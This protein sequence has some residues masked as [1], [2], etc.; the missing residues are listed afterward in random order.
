[1]QQELIMLM[2]IS[3]YA[4]GK[5]YAMLKKRNMDNYQVYLCGEGL[6]IQVLQTRLLVMFTP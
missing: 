5:T 2:W 1:M 3:K 6:A 4:K